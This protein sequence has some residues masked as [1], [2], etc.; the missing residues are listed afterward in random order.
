M[1]KT[2]QESKLMSDLKKEYH[3]KLQKIKDREKKEIEKIT[4]KL[5][6]EIINNLIN[7]KDFAFKFVELLKNSEMK[8]GAE[9]IE[10]LNQYY[11]INK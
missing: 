7:N 6:T 10:E 5:G 9:I 4:Y 1:K 2:K 3:E 8:K 11:V